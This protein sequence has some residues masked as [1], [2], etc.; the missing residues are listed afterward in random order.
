MPELHHSPSDAAEQPSLFVA[1][2]AEA[3]PRVAQSLVQVAPLTEHST[4][5]ACALPYK[6]YLRLSNHTRNT[7][8]CFLSD[9]K[10]LS[11]FL[12]HETP[13][14][15]VTRDSLADWLTHLR[16]ERGSAP[17]PKTMARRATF[18]KNFFGWL[19]REEVIVSDP[20]SRISLS[21]PSPPLPEL[22]F[23]DEVQRL[24][25]AAAEEVRCA[26]LVMLLLSAGLKKEEIEQLR[27]KHI[28][29]SNPEHPAVEIHFP[30]EAKRR[31]ERR[32]ELPAE[33]TA[34]Y[35]QYLERYRPQEKLF[36]CTSR[37]LNYVLAAA[38]K[39]AKIEKRVTLQLLRDIYAVRQLRAGV[40]LD[41][42]REKLG[43]S[44]EAW[45]EIADKY[46]KLAFPV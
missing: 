32:M 9:L 30:G 42:L 33:W 28:D 21:R 14:N 24:E 25:A 2:V 29:I 43:L 34:T 18:L 15:A 19:V 3:P 23:E 22:L 10:M 35:E 7:A 38:V 46:R 39:R 8:T 20:S 6:E 27:L 17:A 11:D 12:G 26:L 5:G 4:L 41:A 44:E 31:R 37:N 36:E 1:G 45:Y 16:W 40:P 13:L